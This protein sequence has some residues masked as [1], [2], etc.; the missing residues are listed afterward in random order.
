MARSPCP[1]LHTL[2]STVER[3]LATE[4]GLPFCRATRLRLRPACKGPTVLNVSFPCDAWQAIQPSII[5]D[6]PI[7]AGPIGNTNQGHHDRH[8]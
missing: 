8:A 1:V 7:S 4:A 3:E 5:R 2:T 6:Q